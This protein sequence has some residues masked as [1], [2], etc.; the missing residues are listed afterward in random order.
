[1]EIEITYAGRFGT[2]L[3]CLV[4]LDDDG[5]V[6]KIGCQTPEGWDVGADQLDGVRL[7]YLI[8]AERARQLMRR[9]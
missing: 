8:A 4:N 6:E 7:N 9:D 2:E 5:L 1:M 3:A